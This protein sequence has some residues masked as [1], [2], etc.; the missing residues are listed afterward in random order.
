MGYKETRGTFGGDREVHYL[1][2]SEVVLWVCLCR[3]SSNVHLKYVHFTVCQVYLTKVVFK[4]M[5][6][7]LYNRK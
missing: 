7:S 2:C 3:N 5:V 1:D 4:K 6:L